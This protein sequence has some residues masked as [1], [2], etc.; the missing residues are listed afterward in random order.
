MRKVRLGLGDFFHK[1]DLEDL[2]WNQGNF[3]YRYLSLDQIRSLNLL[4]EVGVR[5]EMGVEVV[6]SI[7]LL[8]FIQFDDI[9]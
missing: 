3:H 5:V 7:S 8:G 4:M 6:V 9:F 1:L 2:G